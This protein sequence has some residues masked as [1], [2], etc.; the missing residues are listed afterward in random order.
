MSAKRFLEMSHQFNQKQP[1]K[2]IVHV[3]QKFAIKTKLS[4][5]SNRRKA[6]AGQKILNGREKG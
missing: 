6:Q 5:I 2:Y 4:G 1:Q 3:I